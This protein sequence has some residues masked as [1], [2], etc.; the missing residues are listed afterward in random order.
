MTQI[1]FTQYPIRGI[2]V[3]QYNLA[4][5]KP[6][7]FSK[8][9]ALGAH[10]VCI[11]S[12]YGIATD[13]AFKSN[14]EGAKGILPRRAYHYLDYFSNHMSQ[15][16]VNGLPDAEWG[17]RQAQ[18]VWS[19]IKDD[20][21]NSIVWLD[22]E[23]PSFPPKVETV[24]SRVITIA[25]AFMAEIDRLTGKMN[26]VYISAGFIST[27]AKSL[28]KRP[29]WVAW[30]NEAQT[31][32]SVINYA[33]SKGWTGK[34]WDWQYA[35]DGDIEGDNIGDGIKM[36]MGGITL[37]L[38]VC[39]L[40]EEEFNKSFTTGIVEPPVVEPPVTNE[41][42]TMLVNTYAL[43]VRN[44]PS[45]LGS[46]VEVMPEGTKVYILNEVTDSTGIV[47]ANIGYKQ[48]CSKSYLK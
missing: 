28:G 37:D 26:G 3:S 30:Y 38:N 6:L 32:D 16:S 42:K 2:D 9:K 8:A 4:N 24:L 12:S 41:I 20:N 48:Y 46:I 17:K 23:S 21:D 11:R 44:K 40:T 7:D 1:N 35:S 47:W 22:I 13:S 43:R 14:W 45:L 36:G 15:Y 18:L 5:K 39:L 27:F 25:V 10:Y 29:L 33:K 31:A 19:L 34:V